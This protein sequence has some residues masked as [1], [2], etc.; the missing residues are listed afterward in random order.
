MNNLNP[1]EAALRKWAEA[2]EDPADLISWWVGA[3]PFY[4]ESE[5]LIHTG[6]PKLVAWYNVDYVFS[7]FDTWRAN[8]RIKWLDEASEQLKEEAI[9]SAWIF[10]ALEEELVQ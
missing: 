7:D 1:N 3:N 6:Y 9:T 4:D 8:L 5:C 2:G 10:L